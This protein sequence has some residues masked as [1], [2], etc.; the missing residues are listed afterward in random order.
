[1]MDIR[2]IHPGMVVDVEVPW[3]DD[4]MFSTLVPAKV[5]AVRRNARTGPYGIS[6]RP[7]TVEWMTPP[8][9]PGGHAKYNTFDADK[10]RPY[11]LPRGRWGHL[12]PE[13]TA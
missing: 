13:A 6:V 2:D 5:L 11:G 9:I 7:V 1:M 4:P 8:P 12:Y 10:I 3:G